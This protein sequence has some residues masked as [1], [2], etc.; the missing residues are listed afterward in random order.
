MS[1]K[2]CSR[3]WASLLI[4]IPALWSSYASFSPGSAV[5]CLSTVAAHADTIVLNS[6]SNGVYSYNLINTNYSTLYSPGSVITFSGLYGVTAA[7]NSFG[8]MSAFST[9][10]TPSS[11]TFTQT[12]FPVGIEFY[13][14]FSNFFSITSASG[15][16]GLASYSSDASP[17]FSGTLNG[18]VAP[19]VA[20]TPEPPSFVLLG[21]V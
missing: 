15:V 7:S 6:V 2:G 3:L 9:T 18:P 13:G 20:V 10:F 14:D 12:S 8:S 5:L 11:V 21:R 1:Y 19:A 4:F 16:L 17:A